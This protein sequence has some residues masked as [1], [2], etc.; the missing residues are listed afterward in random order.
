MTGY[1]ARGTGFSSTTRV[2][3]GCVFLDG[4]RRFVR[5]TWLASLSFRN[6]GEKRHQSAYQ[7]YGRYDQSDPLHQVSS[8]AG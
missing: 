3:A 6:R 2:G 4:E 1:F 7:G 8:I 5:A